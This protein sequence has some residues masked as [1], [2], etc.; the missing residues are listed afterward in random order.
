MNKGKIVFSGGKQQAL[1]N[2][3]IFKKNNLIR[4]FIVE[5]SSK[6]KYYELTEGI[7]TN[8]DKLVNDIWK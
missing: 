2:E 4:P 1:E 3:K 6:L 8:E 7:Y 5:L